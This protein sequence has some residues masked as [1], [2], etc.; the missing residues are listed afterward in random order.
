M[1]RIIILVYGILAYCAFFATITYAIGFVTGMFVPKGIDSGALGPPL[2]STLI[3]LVLVIFFGAAHSAMARPAFKKSI[4]KFIPAS[5]ERSTFVLVASLQL[6]IVFWL[7]QPLTSVAWRIDSPVIAWLLNAGALVGWGLVFW[8]SFLIN[9]F[10]LFGLR[11]VWLNFKGL[12]YSPTPFT[13][14]GLYKY[15]RHPLMLGFLVAFWLTPFMTVGHLLFAASM[16]VYI[17]IG[18]ALEE[19]D[20]AK[21][22]SEEY[23]RY[24]ESTAMILPLVKRR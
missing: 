4:T 10:D 1:Q 17:L 24:H 14:R 8:S 9:H 23:S 15:V 11:Q 3:D 7:W 12:P 21:Y 18:I 19:R 2:Q 22:L 13:V 5:A 6:A 20:L 16:T